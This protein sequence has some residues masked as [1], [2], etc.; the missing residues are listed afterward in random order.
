VPSRHLILP[1]GVKF[2]P[3]TI[4]KEPQRGRDVYSIKRVFYSSANR[5]PR[6]QRYAA[7]SYR[8]FRNDLE[9][10][11]TFVERLNESPLKSTRILRQPSNSIITSQVMR[12]YSE[13]LRIQTVNEREARCDFGY[14]KRYLVEFFLN[15]LKLPDPMQ[16]HRVH[17]TKWT[18]FLLG[19][20]APKSML[21]KRDVI[22]ASNRFLKW[23][24]SQYPAEVPFLKFE[25]FSRARIR[26]YQA[27]RDLEPGQRKRTAISDADWEK[28]K[29]ALPFAI[30]P[31]VLLAYHY[32]LRR[33]ETLGFDSTNDVRNDI[34]LVRK[35]MISFTDGHALYGPCKTRRERSVPH[36][37]GI[38]PDQTYQWILEGLG[39]KMHPDTLSDHWRDLIE[40]IGLEYTFHELRHTFITRARAEYNSREV[41]LA[42]GHAN[43]TT[44]E[45]Y[46]HDHRKFD[47][48]IFKS[49][50]KMA[51]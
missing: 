12:D 21:T 2:G 27:T 14:V 16:W 46:S 18:E 8:Y 26:Q 47:D 30:K 34:L 17:Q 13:H 10:L 3:W 39:Q 37:L 35:Q 43:I 29:S 48:D 23:L 51:A 24:H 44:T 1:G 33:A 20:D 50:E 9:Q 31:F 32:G 42:A 6:Y 19:P 7:K 22:Y 4:Y 38:K 25:P 49:K 28:I 36:W 5:K 40:K 11:K 15:Q 41:Q 45:R